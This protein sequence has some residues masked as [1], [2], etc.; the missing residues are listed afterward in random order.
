VLGELPKAGAAAGR[1]GA[2]PTL[3]RRNGEQ[4]Q[5]DGRLERRLDACAG[6][7]REMMRLGLLVHPT[8]FVSKTLSMLNP[9][10]VRP[11]SFAR[12]MENAEPDSAM[13]RL[14]ADGQ[15]NWPASS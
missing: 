7:P 6:L 3:I 12:A 5:L 9:H 13:A 15:L 8:I 1:L 11:E 2:G 10:Y 14:Y 4:R